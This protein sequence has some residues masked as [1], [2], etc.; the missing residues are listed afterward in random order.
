MSEVLHYRHS[1]RT[2]MNETT[3][4]L[5]LASVH[6]IALMSPGPDFALIVQNVSVHGRRTGLYIALGLSSGI[7]I[8]SLLSLTGISFLIQQ[9]PILSVLFQLAGG[10][11]LFNLGIKALI[12]VWQ[13]CKNKASV[14]ELKTQKA[15]QLTNQKQAFI[16]GFMTNILNPKALVFFTSL[17]SSLIPISM[18]F[19]GKSIAIVI[20]F[21]LALFW[22]SLLAWTLSAKRLQQKL[23]ACSLY[24]DGICGFFF[25]VIGSSILWHGLTS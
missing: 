3:I 23:L 9:Y 12:S 14:S 8:H 16:R 1:S 17:M 20:L 2:L 25:T 15:D 21:V 10:S 18:S 5:T 19:M 11:Y 24:I 4:L 7:L 13:R 6:F 22:F